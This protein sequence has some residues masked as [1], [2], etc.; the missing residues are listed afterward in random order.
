MSGALFDNVVGAIDGMLIWTVKPSKRECKQEK[1]GEKNF[2]CSRKDKFGLNLQAICDHRLKFTWI[3][4]RWPGATSD[5]MAW[6]TSDLCH[7]LETTELLLKDKC[8]VGDN[9]YIKKKYV[10]S[11]ERIGWRL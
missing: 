8:I 9:A 11:I 2:K 1:C 4:I 7:K 6:V 5:Y 10:R 3:D